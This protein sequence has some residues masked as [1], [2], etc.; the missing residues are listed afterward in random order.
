VSSS[1]DR[2]PH[3]PDRPSEW[4]ALWILTSGGLGLA[5]VAPGT[6]GTL[7]GVALAVPLVYVPGLPYWATLLAV[8]TLLVGVG[9]VLGTIGERI[10]GGKDPGQIVLD[11]VAGYL[12]TVAVFAFFHGRGLQFGGHVAAF[13]LFRVADILKPPPGR[14]LEKL[15]G[16]LG[17]MMDD[18]VLALYSGAALAAL[19]DW[20][21]A[22]L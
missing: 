12:V 3:R 7:G 2:E 14:A 4:V 9:V 17:V 20:G 22:W 19:G 13:L 11:E 15:P 16:G 6:F 8:T 18:V 5:P 21:F 10:F 1:F